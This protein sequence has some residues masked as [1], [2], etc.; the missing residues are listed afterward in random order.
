MSLKVL[1]R[2]LPLNYCG[3]SHARSAATYTSRSAPP[4]GFPR[5]PLSNVHE[6]AN[7]PPPNPI[8]PPQTPLAPSDTSCF[9]VA[10]KFGR[11]SATCV[12]AY[13]L[14]YRQLHTH[15]LL[16]PP[17]R[18]N[19]N[20]RRS[21]ASNFIPCARQAIQVRTH[22]QARARPTRAC[23]TRARVHRAPRASTRRRRG[24]Q[25]KS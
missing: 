4:P 11:L 19:C 7:Y 1:Y 18:S 15:Q 23:P 6:N 12:P 21:P 17:A 10:R 16:P 9:T 22:K 3:R 20:L 2:V 24:Q 13:I 14:Y 25:H 8:P 5:T